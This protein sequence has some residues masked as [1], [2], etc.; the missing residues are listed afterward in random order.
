MQAGMLVL[1][2]KLRN[3]SATSK[4]SKLPSPTGLCL[5]VGP[6]CGRLEWPGGIASEPSRQAV[7]K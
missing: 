3:Q 6:S 5:D 7:T 4:G 1:D 2:Q